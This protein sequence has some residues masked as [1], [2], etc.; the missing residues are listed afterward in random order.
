MAI[1]LEYEYFKPQALDEAV[2]LKARFG[3]EGRFLAGGT[4]LV[5]NLNDESCRPQAVIDL[6]GIKALKKLEM[7]SRGLFLG[8]LVTFSELI[9]SRTVKSRYPLLWE[10]AREVASTGIRNRATVAGNICSCVPCMDSA[11]PLVAYRAIVLIRGPEGEREIPASEFFRGPRK[12]ALKDGEVLAGL[13]L[14]RPPKHGAA[15]LKQKRYRGEDLA[16]SNV[17][18]LALEG[19]EYRVVFGSVGPTPLEAGKIEKLLKGKALTA[20]LAAEARKLVRKEIAPIDDLRSS[21]EYR[22]IMAEVMLERG[23]KA[24]ADRLK[25]KGLAYGTPLV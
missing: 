17:A 7:T 10:S 2:A 15:F 16:Q 13:L 23:L 4:D 18:V 3:A 12:T 19:K 20:K 5:N 11:P 24:A 22:F 8:P 21:R 9:D 25:G 6:K 1:A 14:P